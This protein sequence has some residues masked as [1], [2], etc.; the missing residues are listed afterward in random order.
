MGGEIPASTGVR[1]DD[2]Q[3]GSARLVDI[4]G[5]KVLLIRIADVIRA[6]SAWCTHART[7]LDE[8]SV[9]ADGLLECPMHGAVFSSADG[10]LQ[11]GPSCD[12]LPVYRVTLAE[13]ETIVVHLPDVPDE[14]KS[15]ER[16]ASPWGP[17]WAMAAAD[18][19]ES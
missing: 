15:P 8:Q 12:P 17:A 10:S 19:E 9:D 11:V 6:T 1:R 16:P 18:R 14:S 7:L 2:L 5:A 13:D 4:D 3:P